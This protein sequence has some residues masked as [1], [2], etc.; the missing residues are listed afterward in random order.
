MLK[1]KNDTTT[2]W[3]GALCFF[4]STIEYMIPKPMPF[5][6]LGLANL[7]ILLALNILPLR[8]FFVLI[9]LKI[10]GQGLIGGTLF[11]YIFLFS[12][13][14]TI[15]S[16]FFMLAF[17]KLFSKSISNIGISVVGALASNGSQLLLARFYIFGISAWYIAPPFLA[18]GV[19]TGTLLGIFANQFAE[20]SRWYK[21]V[22]SGTIQYETIQSPDNNTDSTPLKHHG[23]PYIIR[24]IFGVLLLISLLFAPEVWIQAIIVFFALILLLIDSTKIQLLPVLF[25]SLSIIIFNLCAPF[26]KILFTL[27]L[28]LPIT[29]GALILGIKKALTIEGMIFISRW[30]MKPQFRLPGTI[31]NLISDAFLILGHITGSRQKLDRK[32]L[33]ASI[34]SIMFGRD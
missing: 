15:C 9:F 19:L 34:D 33:I 21:E 30:M 8:S 24:F 5:L 22:S 2:A 27:P 13:L 10:L 17:K 3:F 23:I 18:L 32:N 1:T 6:R 31:G 7:P 12:A 11:S 25:M 4:L 14:G 16:A 29:E 20:K 28:N 26:G